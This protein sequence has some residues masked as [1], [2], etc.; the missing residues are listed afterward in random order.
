MDSNRTQDFLN[1]HKSCITNQNEDKL[2][3]KAICKARIIRLYVNKDNKAMMLST[4]RSVIMETD[5][6]IAFLDAL[7]NL[8]VH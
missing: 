8:S 5:H 3:N 4:L 2:D 7:R 1:F 6:S